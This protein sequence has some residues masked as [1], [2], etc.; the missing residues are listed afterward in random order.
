VIGVTIIEGNDRGPP[1]Q[2][3]ISQRLAQLLEADDLIVA[4]QVLAILGK[5]SRSDTETRGIR[6]RHGDRWSSSRQVTE[7]EE[8]SLR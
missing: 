1:R 7:G 5:V 4:L 6:G 2:P 3:V 8:I